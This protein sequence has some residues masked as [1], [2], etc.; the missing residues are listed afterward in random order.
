MRK[1]SGEQLQP[2]DW[3]ATKA[4]RAA[5]ETDAGILKLTL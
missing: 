1:A 2:V 5:S 3:W 4:A